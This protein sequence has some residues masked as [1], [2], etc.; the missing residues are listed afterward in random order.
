MGDTD[1]VQPDYVVTPGAI[2]QGWLD[3]RH[4]TQGQL[5]ERMGRSVKFV[6]QLINGHASLSHEVALEL[7][8]VTGMPAR[9]WNNME[10]T[11]REDVARLARARV[12][13]EQKSWV[14]SLP[15]AEM[16]K[17]GVV[18]ATKRHFDTLVQECLCFFRV[19]SVS[20]WQS[21]Y[22]NQVAALYR[23]AP[24]HA[25]KQNITATW[26][27]LGEMEAEMVDARPFDRTALEEAI[28][29]LRALSAKGETEGLIDEVQTI[30]AECGVVLVIVPNI[31][32]TR[33]YGATRWIAGRPVVQ[34]SLLRKSVDQFWFTLFHELGHVL[35]HDKQDL[36]LDYDG[37]T[38]P[39]EEQANQFASETLIPSLH[40]ERLSALYSAT[41]VKSFAAEIGISAAV[42]VG[43]L[44]RE[45]SNY[46]WCA[47]LK[48]SL[49]V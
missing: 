21:V 24:S 15:L 23:Q 47:A 17:R 27:R 35:L 29:S 12:T 11:Y 28:P 45:R 25:Q 49:D 20:A 1:V 16:R 32:G 39:L 42:V 43:R 6:N 5:A 37:L 22:G 7:E 33:L 36:F 2:L 48:P 44:Q 13:E 40:D 31:P 8:T 30:L 18:T 41:E 26:L 3:E 19:N 38:S 9:L 10:A 4:M 34:M 46:T 14:E